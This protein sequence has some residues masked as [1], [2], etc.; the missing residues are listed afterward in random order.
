MSSGKPIVRQ[1]AWLSRS[2][3]AEYY[4]KMLELFPDSELAKTSLKMMESIENQPAGGQS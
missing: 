1:A 3:T 2:P 4:L